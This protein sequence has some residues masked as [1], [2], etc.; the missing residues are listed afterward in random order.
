MATNISSDSALQDYE[1]SR[2]QSVTNV[3]MQGGSI[4][5]R[6]YR[7]GTQAI[8]IKMKSP[9][10]GKDE[11][12]QAK[13]WKYTS[14]A[15]RFM[16]RTKQAEWVDRL[17]GTKLKKPEKEE[18]RDTG[19]ERVSQI[20]KTQTG[21]LMRIE[22][23]INAV[24]SMVAAQGAAIE[25]IRTMLAPRQLAVG[26]GD[27]QQNITF[28]PLAPKGS[29]FFQTDDKGNLS[30]KQLT[31]EIAEKAAVTVVKLQMKEEER[32]GK[33]ARLM[34]KKSRQAGVPYADPEEGA[35]P[36]EIL[37]AEMDAN[38]KRV[39]EALSGK[40][41]DEESGGWI[42]KVMKFFSGI[43]SK[44][45][46]ILGIIGKLGLVGIAAKLGWE[47]GKWL[48][49]K[50][51]ISERINDAIFAVKDWFARLD[52]PGKF[53]AVMDWFTEIKQSILQTYEDF[54]QGIAD[55][56]YEIKDW[57][58]QQIINIK[59][60]IHDMNPFTDDEET[61]AYRRSL[62][63]KFDRSRSERDAARMAER[64]D[65]ENYRT[66]QQMTAELAKSE[67]LATLQKQYA[68]LDA[69]IKKAPEGKYRDF[70][71]SERSRTMEAMETKAPGSSAVH[72]SQM[73]YG[74]I[75]R[76]GL[77]M[78]DETIQDVIVQA[79]K[80]VGV[81][82]GLMMAMA[83]QES[84]FN[85]S[86]DAKTSSAKGLYQFINSTWDYMLQK[87]GGEFP[88]LGAGP[89]D[90]QASAIAGALFIKENAEA[91]KKAGIPLT[92]SNL[93]TAHFLGAGGARTLLS[94][95]SNSIAADIL[96]AAA[97]ANK[98]IFYDK[99]GRARTVSEVEGLMY[100]KIGAY[101]DAYTAA[102]GLD[103]NKG[104]VMA[105]QPHRRIDGTAVDA[106]SREVQQGQR[107]G[108]GTVSVSTPVVVH[109]TPVQTPRP[110]VG[111]PKPEPFTT[112]PA[113]AGMAN[114]DSSF[115][116]LA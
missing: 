53:Y 33:Q 73:S 65:K 2:V 36:L 52:I 77:Q 51:K 85:P 37:R 115:P 106:V 18:K 84:G 35:S 20:V 21:S 89:Y 87:Y 55:K 62:Q 75:E 63:E 40:G 47:L 99:H 74:T 26:K 86:A 17:T 27:Q 105:G 96:P 88:E 93:Y 43:G 69:Q 7:G 104:T 109:N 6:L 9:W 81:D 61:E 101:A 56:F 32:R 41:A 11:I 45:L 100:E 59:V 90:P 34:L 57:F 70:L 49:E 44:L 5:R 83:R 113:L 54:K 23:K 39:F 68:D 103:A 30:K 28:N 76:K 78:P 14:N 91:L 64:K 110:Q 46:P 3:M 48:N 80:K 10:R 22:H 108:A 79:A 111:T 95:P 4:P 107:G 13:A 92:A 94:A 72:R 1:A 58:E 67:S 102:L 97:K 38:F 50:F 66:T 114:R 15:L 116:S 112:D 8:K 24:A 42:S 19:T 60:F 82:T 29:E 25:N 71:I 31:D 98:G 16:G 12:E